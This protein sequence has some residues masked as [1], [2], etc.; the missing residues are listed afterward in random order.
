MAFKIDENITFNVIPMDG[1]YQTPNE[2][3]IITSLEYSEVSLLLMGDLETTVE[4]NNLHKF[5]DIDVLKVGHHG[6]R[7][8]TC[9]DFIDIINPEDSIISAGIDNKFLLPNADVIERLSSS[10]SKVYGT[11][12]SGDIIMS[13]DGTNYSIDTETILVREDAGAPYLGN[14]NNNSN[15]NNAS[16]VTEKEAV[17]VGNSET[18]KFHLMDCFAGSRI[19]DRRTI[20]FKYRQDAIDEGYVPCKICNP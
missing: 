8:A 14:Q 17:Y 12:R 3:S 4:K 13:T 1:N 19:A 2:N 16:H 7:T 6:S 20:Y 18:K 11:F 5:K 10:D 9:Q 15:S